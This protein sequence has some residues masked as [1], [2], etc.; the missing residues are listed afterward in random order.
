[1]ECIAR[2]AFI[3]ESTGNCRGLCAGALFEDDFST[4]LEPSMVTPELYWVRELEPTRLALLPRPR[5]N[6]WLN[7]EVTGWQRAGIN[8]IVSLLEA[9]E[10]RELGLKEEASLCRDAGIEFLSY[11]VPD[12]GTPSSV[13]K[14]R[15]LVEDLSSRLHRNEGVGIHCRAG[16][17]RTGLLGACVA[18]ELG[19][20]LHEVFPL[21]SRARGIQVPD[22][23]AQVEWVRRFSRE[24]KIGF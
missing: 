18:L 22:T 10:I 14:T 19:V 16:I 17:G 1:M 15:V 20:P 4:A 5:S 2:R 7:D 13:R 3:L 9:Q 23:E 21:L 8:T 6:D 12:R 11:P 24:R